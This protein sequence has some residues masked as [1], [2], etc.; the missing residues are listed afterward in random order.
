MSAPPAA[1]LVPPAPQ[2]VKR[3]SRARTL[4]KNALSIIGRAHSERRRIFLSR[5]LSSPAR[6][7]NQ[8][9]NY[10]SSLSRALLVCACYSKARPKNAARFALLVLPVAIGL[11][12]CRRP[13]IFL[14][15]L[16]A[17]ASSLFPARRS[18]ARTAASRCKQAPIM[19]E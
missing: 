14:W 9:R 10:E 4:V 2:P 13:V 1:G 16:R 12:P 8:Q 6:F 5:A 7:S 11:R 19:I 15:T 3:R 17:R 18:S